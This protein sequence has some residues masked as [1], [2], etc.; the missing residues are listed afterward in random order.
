MERYLKRKESYLQWNTIH[1][2]DPG[3]YLAISLHKSASASCTSGSRSPFIYMIHLRQGCAFFMRRWKITIMKIQKW[4][5]QNFLTSTDYLVKTTRTHM[6]LTL[7]Q[8]FISKMWIVLH[9]DAPFKL[10]YKT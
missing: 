4:I 9:A 2:I 1:L 7:F 8:L 3:I 5:S 10:F 6:D